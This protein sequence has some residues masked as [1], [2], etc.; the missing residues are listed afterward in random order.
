MAQVSQVVK[1]PSTCPKFGTVGILREV[2]GME[3]YLCFHWHVLSAKLLSELQFNS[4]LEH[5]LHKSVSIAGFQCLRIISN[6]TA[7]RAFLYFR[8]EPACIAGK[9]LE[10]LETCAGCC[11][12]VFYQQKS[13]FSRGNL[14]YTKLLKE[15]SYY[16]L[17]I[18]EIVSQLIII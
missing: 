7:Q 15:H 11:K 4:V 9:A 16:L 12:P 1:L 14:F 2:L 3:A 8:V 17:I 6:T 18:S 13:Y 10:N 5:P